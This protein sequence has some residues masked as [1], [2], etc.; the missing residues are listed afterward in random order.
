MDWYS[1]IGNNNY[2]VFAGATGLYRS[3]RYMDESNLNYL[4]EFTRVNLRFGIE[5]PRYR[6]MAYVDNLFDDDEI[7]NGQ[8]V[9][10]LGDPDGFAPGRGYLL[11]MPLPRVYGLRLSAQF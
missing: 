1:Q 2:E 9:V 11:H 4:P 8:R 5:N 3:K 6:L 7:T 10:D